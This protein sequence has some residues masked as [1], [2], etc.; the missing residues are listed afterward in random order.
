MMMQSNSQFHGNRAIVTNA[1]AAQ[2]I[3]NPNHMSR[4]PALE[5]HALQIQT[6]KASS[7]GKGLIYL[8]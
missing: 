8:K 3:T 2:R 7:F 4:V 5:T 6:C 1:T